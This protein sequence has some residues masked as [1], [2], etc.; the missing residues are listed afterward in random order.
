MMEG[1]YKIMTDPGGP[2]K[3]RSGSTILPFRKNIT[4]DGNLADL[5]VAGLG[6]VRIVPWSA[7]VLVTPVHTVR[8]VVTEQLRPK[9]IRE[10]QD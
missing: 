6:P 9:Q 5:V 2:K 4:L 3:Y 1:T 7:Q 10:R 8:I